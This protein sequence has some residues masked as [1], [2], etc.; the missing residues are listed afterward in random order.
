MPNRRKYEVTTGKNTPDEFHMGEYHA[1][2]TKGT[3][4]LQ[5]VFGDYLAQLGYVKD[6]PNAEPKIK[7]VKSNLTARDSV[8]EARRAPATVI[9]TNVPEVPT[10]ELTAKTPEIAP[11]ATIK[12][13]QTTEKG[14]KS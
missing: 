1:D 10:E 11:K 9:V 6:I 3:V 5:P 2:L 7:T 12:A 13:Q 4:M 8:G 14:D